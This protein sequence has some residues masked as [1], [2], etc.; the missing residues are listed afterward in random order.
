MIQKNL[1]K[2]VELEN[3][4]VEDNVLLTIASGATVRIKNLV[5]GKGVMIHIDNGSL[6]VDSGFADENLKLS[7]CGTL[8]IISD[9]T[10]NGRSS[11]HAENIEICLIDAILNVYMGE[12]YLDNYPIIGGE[13]ISGQGGFNKIFASKKHIFDGTTLTGKFISD[14]A[15][16]EWFVA[17]D[18]DNWAPAINSAFEIAGEVHLDSRVY[19]V[20]ETIWIPPLGQLI[21]CSG[22]DNG[23]G[24]YGTILLPTEAT[25]SELNFSENY[26]IKI[27]L[28]K[29]S[30]SAIVEY[31]NPGA[32][33]ANLKIDNHQINYGDSNF[34]NKPLYGIKVAFSAEIENIFFESLI[35][36][37][38]WTS[39]YADLK[40]ITRCSFENMKNNPLNDTDYI[41]DFGFLG[42]ALI[43]EGNG[44]HGDENRNGI[45]IHTCN[46]GILTSNII[47]ADVM[48]RSSK[49]ITFSNNHMERGAQIIIDQ[50]DVTVSNNYIMKGQYPSVVIKSSRYGDSAVVNLNNNQYIYNITSDDY[51]SENGICNYDIGVAGEKYTEEINNTEVERC[52]LPQCVINVSNE[53]RYRVIFDEIGKNVMSG[54]SIGISEDGGRTFRAAE[55][56][57]HRSQIYS[58]SSVIT[59]YDG[60]LNVSYPPVSIKGWSSINV[61]FN[62]VG[63]DSGTLSSGHY[64]YYSQIILDYERKWV[65]PLQSV[66]NIEINGKNHF[67]LFL[68]F[69]AAE[70]GSSV[71]VRMIRCRGTKYD[72]PVYADIP[73][74]NACPFY[75]DGRSVGGYNWQQ[76][77]NFANAIFY[78]TLPTFNMFTLVGDT[79]I[80]ED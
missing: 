8:K 38:R 77:G 44:I 2:S 7:G 41:V 67:I 66:A 40:K 9:F 24:G 72:N 56:F 60:K 65:T 43:F 39:G 26:I 59:V 1:S 52:S 49:G 19:K 4:Q 50:S 18:T 15:Y 36:G 5:C 28:Q 42:D 30:N 55:T 47:N 23:D 74:V 35:V 62:A 3:Y 21:G 46:S 22:G 20:R 45:L 11:I 70:L 33:V 13:I 14:V 61:N 53:L 68:L 80:T 57:N 32:K 64:Y 6:I 10:I 51:K 69:G 78:G 76:V 29:D 79:V 48:I 58:R 71:M 31:P 63:D 75:D 17:D 16:P 37:I 12:L 27:N 73:L 54:I 25:G 34:T